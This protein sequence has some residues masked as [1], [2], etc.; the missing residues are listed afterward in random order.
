MTVDEAKKILLAANLNPLVREALN[1]LLPDLLNYYN[2]P[3]EIWR[4]IKG[5]EGYYQISNLGRVKSF[6]KGK[7]KILN[8]LPSKRGYLRVDL[9]RPN[10]R[11]RCFVHVLVAEAFVPNPENKPQ[12][13]HRDGNKQNNHFKNLEWSTG[14]E[15]CQHA[16]D[17]GLQKSGCDRK[18]SKLTAEQ[19][20]E[21]R[22]DCIPGDND[23]G[24][25]PL[26]RK[27]NVSN[28][29]VKKVF[30]RVTYKNVE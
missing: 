28:Q 10:K 22:R 13:N 14:S 26:G 27:F 23:F 24:Y 7:I 9:R 25:R 3:G 17:T 15:N 8:V 16:Y 5:F 1:V 2:L 29:T 6:C 19:V 30:Y 11:R 4:D 20:R 21:I 12:I 18:N